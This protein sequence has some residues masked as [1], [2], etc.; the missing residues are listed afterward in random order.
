MNT[1]T[2]RCFETVYVCILFFFF[3]FVTMTEVCYFFSG[4]FYNPFSLSRCRVT[5]VVHSFSG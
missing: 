3:S 1:M 4:Q 5:Q 2:H